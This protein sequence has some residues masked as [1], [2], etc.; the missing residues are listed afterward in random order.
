MRKLDKDTPR[1]VKRI[2]RRSSPGWQVRIPP[3]AG[4]KGF[5]KFFADRKHGGQEDAKAA[6]SAFIEGNPGLLPVPQP[7]RRNRPPQKSSSEV[8][9]VHY[10]VGANPNDGAWRATWKGSDGYPTVKSFSARK[11]GYETAYGMAVRIRCQAMGIPPPRLLKAPPLMNG[12]PAPAIAPP[13]RVVKRP[14]RASPSG[15]EYRTT[16]QKNASGFVGVCISTRAGHPCWQA[17]WRNS[18][19]KEVKRAFSWARYGYE[20]AYSLAVEA[21]CQ[22]TGIPVPPVLVAP[23]ADMIPSSSKADQLALAG[24]KRAI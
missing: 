14:R 8:V 2:D 18:S 22:A 5:T 4:T 19:G 6:A 10:R 9:G 23:P 11:Y 16:N 17:Y 21:R 12:R 3:S 20:R 13:Q 1:Y 15:A 24:A 7:R